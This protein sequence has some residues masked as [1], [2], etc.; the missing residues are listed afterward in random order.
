MLPGSIHEARDAGYDATSYPGH[1]ITNYR[2]SHSAPCLIEPTTAARNPSESSIGKLYPTEVFTD[3]TNKRPRFSVWDWVWEF[4]ASIFSLGSLAAV[5]AVLAANEHK[6][7][8][9][10]TFVFG[11]SLNT[12]IAILSTLSRTALMVPVASCIS[13]L[14]WIHLISASRPLCEVQVFE[15]ASRGPWGSFGLLWKLHVRAKLA[16]WGCV[17]TILTLAMGPFAQQLI[18]YPLRN[19]V[20]GRATFYT[21]HVY[22]SAYGQPRGTRGATASTMGPKMQ[23]AMLN[24]LF[25]LS[26]PMQYTCS[27]GNCQW[28]DF[29]TL[30][31]ASSCQNVTST[32]KIVCRAEAGARYCNYTTP[33]GLFIRASSWQSSGGGGATRFNSTAITPDVGGSSW[34]GDRDGPINSTLATIAMAALSNGFNL[35]MPDLM[36]CSMRLCARVT[37]NLTVSNGTF[38]PGVSEDFELEGVPG[39][40]EI[41]MRPGISSPRDWFTFNTTG[42]HPSYPGNRSFSYNAIDLDGV[43]GFLRTI[44]S[45]DVGTPYYLSLMDSPD[46]AGTVALISESMSYAF[47]HAPSG[48]ELEGRMLSDELYIEVHWIWIILPLLEVVMSLTFLVCTLIHT[49]RKGVTVWKSSGIVPLLTVM[50][51]WDNS[52][53]GAASGRDVEKRSKKMRGRLVA[54]DGNVQGFHRTE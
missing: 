28:D 13:Q 39:R 40:Y 2:D 14:K 42:D 53:L 48:D 34:S 7:L 25:N 20:S 19:V 15:D 1:D 27:T 36:E 41:D 22:D 3:P 21:S 6:S 16:T 18:S 4:G 26:S 31:V 17:I 23:G 33:S 45:P 37:R 8:A 54:N 9:N 12:L 50:V 32:S 49:Q 11:I 46:R 10:W 35:T 38:I 5:V 29:S 44:F 24:G 30:A 47:A 43:K 51:G 52:E